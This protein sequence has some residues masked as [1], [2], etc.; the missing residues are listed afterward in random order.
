MFAIA[1]P[2]SIRN[3]ISHGIFFGLNYSL[4]LCKLRHFIVLIKMVFKK[5]RSSLS[6][7]KYVRFLRKNS[8]ISL[9]NVLGF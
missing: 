3:N 1:S 2:T 9:R 6:K 4:S 5:K 8:E 7:N